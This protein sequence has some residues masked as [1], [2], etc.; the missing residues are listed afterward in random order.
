M[1]WTVEDA[2]CAIERALTD[3]A[4]PIEVTKT[5]VDGDDVVVV[6]V[7]AARPGCSFAFRYPAHEDGDESAESV[8]RLV[9]ANLA[10]EVEA[11]DRGLPECDPGGRA[12]LDV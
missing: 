7:A 6:F 3:S 12:W 5:S 10:E 2:R 4:L 9:V 8:G 1:P 11:A